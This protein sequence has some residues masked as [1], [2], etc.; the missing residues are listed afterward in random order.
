MNFSPEIQAATDTLVSLAVKDPNITYLLEQV[1]DCTIAGVKEESQKDASIWLPEWIR[2]LF[3]GKILDISAS[4][5]EQLKTLTARLFAMSAIINIV[6]SLN[7]EVITV[8]TNEQNG[9]K[10]TYTFTAHMWSRHRKALEFTPV[11]AFTIFD[12]SDALLMTFEGIN[13][14]NISEGRFDLSCRI[15]V[16]TEPDVY[17]DMYNPTI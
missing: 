17:K 15:V 3:Y 10:Q 14:T 2:Y 6:K 4:P 1:A 16:T 9:A 7:N 8:E 5:S 11:D 12:N 13:K